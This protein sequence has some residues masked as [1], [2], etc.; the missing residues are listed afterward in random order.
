[1]VHGLSEIPDPKLLI[2]MEASVGIIEVP[3]V[4]L[5]FIAPTAGAPMAYRPVVGVI[6][7]VGV[8][9]DRYALGMGTWSLTK[10][11][12]VRD[13]TLIA[14]EAINTANER[15]VKCGLKPFLPKETRRNVVTVGIDL[16]TLI[17]HVFKVGDITMLGV[18]PAGGC[19]RPSHTARKPGFRQFFSR[20]AGIRAKIL[21]SGC[22][23]IG[24][25]IECTRFSI[26]N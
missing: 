12:E 7:G 25:A 1:M 16:L 21:R 4:Q 13:I 10:D 26:A 11:D 6:A 22:I 5:I 17:G 8:V 18:G 19:D 24:D 14:R 2:P 9:Q 20:D 3:R 15:L 23:R